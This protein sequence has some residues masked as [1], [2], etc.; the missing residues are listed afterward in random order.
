MKQEIIF[1]L[2]HNVS[3]Y[4]ILFPFSSV[5]YPEIKKQTIK[6]KMQSMKK[7]MDEWTKKVIF[8]YWIP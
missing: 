7:P 8:I 1:Y 5:Y 3:Y 4:T 6:Q 2:L